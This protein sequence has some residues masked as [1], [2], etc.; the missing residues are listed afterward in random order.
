MKPEGGTGIASNEQR[1]YVYVHNLSI[2]VLI[3]I[4]VIFFSTL[5]ESPI[6][7]LVYVCVNQH[8]FPFLT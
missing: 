7:L 8:T 1:E 6:L 3:I 2:S 5:C 4:I